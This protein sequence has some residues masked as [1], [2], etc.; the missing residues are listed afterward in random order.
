MDNK[1]TKNFKRSNQRV[2]DVASYDFPIA[3]TVRVYSYAYYDA[4]YGNNIVTS[5]RSLPFLLDDSFITK[6]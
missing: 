6:W 4:M 3:A 2:L 1:K 5:F